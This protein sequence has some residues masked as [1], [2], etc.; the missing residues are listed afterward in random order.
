MATEFMR[1]DF[2][3]EWMDE[4]TGETTCEVTIERESDGHTIVVDVWR[5][6]TGTVTYRDVRV[7]PAR[8]IPEFGVENDLAV[9]VDTPGY[10]LP[11]AVTFGIAKS[12]GTREPADND[13]MFFRTLVEALEKGYEEAILRHR[14]KVAAYRG[15]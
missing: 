12:A 6:A 9:L 11:V 5:P 13:E 4:E 14:E 15:E 3:G 2:G 1:T 10:D 7:F 8:G